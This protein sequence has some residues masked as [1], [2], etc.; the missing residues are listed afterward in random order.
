MKLLWHIVTLVVAGI[1]AG[2]LG[3][4]ELV[5]TPKGLGESVKPGINAKFID[6][7]LKVD[8][9]LKRFEVESREVFNE[10]RKVLAAC[11][12]EKGM[13][14]ADIGAGTGLY[15][16][17]FSEA[18]G[19]DGWVF[20]VE[21]SGNFLGHIVAR[22]TQEGQE[23]ITGVLCA[24][25]AVG[26]PPNSVDLAFI[27]DTY[28]HFEYPAATMGSLVKAMKQGGTVVVVDFERIPG[29]SRDWLLGHVRAGKEVFRK[30]IED[31]GLTFVEEVKID[32]FKENYF[33][34]FRK[35]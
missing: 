31:A 2:P 32:G 10:R 33:L 16:R 18:T 15:T 34:R 21:I 30:E 20:A 11:G 35:K 26:L 8:D 22:A 9:W 27:C 23:N 14:V 3:G 24:P 29:K 5:K 25:N 4:E 6:P 28:H 7:D 13:V 17:L 1:L 19:P 12:I